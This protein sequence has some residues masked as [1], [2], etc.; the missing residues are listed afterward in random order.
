MA[1][2]PQGAAG[3]EVEPG[4]AAGEEQP[5]RLD[6]PGSRELDEALAALDALAR[7][8]TEPETPTAPPQSPEGPPPEAPPQPLSGDQIVERLRSQMAARREGTVPPAGQAADRLGAGSVPQPDWQHE[9]RS[10]AARAFRRLR[11][12]IPG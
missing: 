11:R 7:P 2:Q 3:A 1:D 10:P 9:R 8:K 12:I 4:K 5:S 6:M